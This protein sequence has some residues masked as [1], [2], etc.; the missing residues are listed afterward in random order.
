MIEQSAKFRDAEALLR[1]DRP[2]E[3]LSLLEEIANRGANFPGL[4]PVLM[5]AF[6]AAMLQ[7]RYSEATN[8]IELHNWG[9]ARMI[10]E[11]IAGQEPNYRDVPLLLAN[12]D[13]LS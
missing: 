6:S 13:N 5:Q 2:S 9:N 10:L 7:N 12:L 11:D 3:A 4:Q 8:S 1:A